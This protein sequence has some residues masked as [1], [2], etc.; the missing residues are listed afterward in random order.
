VKVLDDSENW[1][2]RKVDFKLHA[3][4]NNAIAQIQSVPFSASKSGHHFGK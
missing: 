2:S 3:L 4:P 1:E